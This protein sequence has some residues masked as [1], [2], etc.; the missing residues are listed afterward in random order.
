MPQKGKKVRK[1]QLP[2]KRRKGAARSG[3]ELKG[4]IWMD[5]PQ[6]TFIGYGRAILLERIREHGSITK[7]AKSMDMSYR[8]AWRLINTMN[9]QAPSPFVITSAGGR[10]GGGTVVT[11]HGENAINVFWEKYRAFQ[12]FLR[13]EMRY[14]DFTK[15]KS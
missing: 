4:R 13:H 14:L 9:E 1:K 12:E 3:Y 7:A 2:E 5:G 6:G 10:G 8:Q 11:E 15:D